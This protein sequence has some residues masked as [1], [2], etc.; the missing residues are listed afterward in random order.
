MCGPP[1]RQVLA[2]N[3]VKNI[4]KK[5]LLILLGAFFGLAIGEAGLRLFGYRYTGS[6]FTLDPLLGW[7]LRPGAG[8]WQVDEGDAWVK[9]NSHGYRDRE[10]AV[11][12]PPGVYRVALLGDSFTEARQVELDKTFASLAEEELNRRHCFRDRRVEVLNFG[13]LGYNTGQELIQLRERGWKFSPDMVVLNFYSGNDIIDHNRALNTVLPELA[14][15]FHLKDGKLELDDSFRRGPKFDPTYIKLKGIATNAMNRFEL[16]LMV[17]KLRV[18]REQREVMEREME[19]ESA[20]KESADPNALP[21]QYSRFMHYLPPTIP[22]MVEAWEVTE[23]LIAEFGK[24]VRSHGA[25]LLML[26]AP[27]PI[28]FHPD[29]KAQEEFRAKYKIESLDYADDRVERQAR[30]NG[31]PT[32]RLAKPLLD[33]ARRT[34]TYMAGFANSPPNEFHLNE[35]GHAVVARE[36]VRAICDIADAQGP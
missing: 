1:A 10:R 20:P 11:S 36:M 21:P 35:R 5:V 7:S 33:E 31:I 3:M 30:A 29:P 28:Q 8:A 32:L 24:E 25:P 12:K 9:I 16:A 23:A 22:P 13:T 18:A 2:T 34:G 4:A 14:P 19:R 26:I 15:Y 6:F 27:L 17:Y